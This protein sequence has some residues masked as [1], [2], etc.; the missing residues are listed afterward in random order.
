V[1]QTSD[2]PAKQLPTE[3]REGVARALA[4]AIEQLVQVGKYE[5]PFTAQLTVTLTDRNGRT[6]SAS[7][8]ASD[9]HVDDAATPA[10]LL[11]R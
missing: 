2:I 10:A 6:W 11:A 9:I 1:A 7:V 4:P 3:Q 5:R 8:M